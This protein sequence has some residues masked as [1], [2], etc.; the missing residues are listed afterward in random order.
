MIRGIKLIID[1][2][3]HGY[4]LYTVFGW[5]FHSIA[6]IWDSVT[7]LILHLGK[8]NQ[9]SEDQQKEQT[10]T[11]TSAP[12]FAIHFVEENKTGK[13]D[14]NESSNLYPHN[15]L[16]E[17][18]NLTQPFSLLKNSTYYFYEIEKVNKN[19]LFFEITADYKKHKVTGL[20]YDPELT[21]QHVTETL[22]TMVP[23]IEAHV[24]NS[25]QSF[26]LNAFKELQ[27]TCKKFKISQPQMLTVRIKYSSTSSTYMSIC[28]ADLMK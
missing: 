27:N 15:Q 28:K 25:Y 8:G 17:I 21:K 16:T 19:E 23:E 6:A 1:T 26:E 11:N 10:K 5:S 13:Q 12:N 20:G 24:S 14:K 2:I 18:S 3:I 4:A 7:N 22:L 9:N